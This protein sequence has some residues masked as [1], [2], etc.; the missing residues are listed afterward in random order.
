MPKTFHKVVYKPSVES[1]E[2]FQVIVNGEEYKKWKGGDTTIP[3]ADVVDAFQVFS[4]GAGTQGIMGKP[5]KQQLDNT[6]NTHNDTEV[7]Q[8]ILEKGELQN[9]TAKDGYSS[10]NDGKMGGNQVSQGGAAHG[11]R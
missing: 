5:S 6:F 1:S 9:A 11:G 10:T 8:I 4:T 2:L 3:L 7:V